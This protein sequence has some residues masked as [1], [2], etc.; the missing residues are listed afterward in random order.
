MKK[1]YF[2]GLSW[3]VAL[4]AYAQEITFVKADIDKINSQLV[5]TYNLNAPGRSYDKYV[6]EVFYS[7][8]NG[9]TFSADPL[10]YATGDIGN[11]I[12]RGIGKQVFWNYFMENAD[13]DGKNL[14]FKLTARLDKQADEARILSLGGPEKALYSVLAPGLGD[15]EVRSGKKYWYITAGV[16]GTLAAGTYLGIKSESNYR[17]YLDAPAAGDASKFL[18]NYHQ[19]RQ[20]AAI[21]ITTAATAWLADVVVA[22]IRGNKNKKAKQQILKLRE[23]ANKK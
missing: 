8:D 10:K 20:L 19:N 13:F 21:L 9:K 4:S 22:A 17:K 12:E 15:Y 5:I 1:C 11:S 7:A 16:L 6:V 2:L 14:V 18:N 23:E 3:L